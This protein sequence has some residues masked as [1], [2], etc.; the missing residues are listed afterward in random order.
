MAREER[1]PESHEAHHEQDVHHV[2]SPTQGK[3]FH[4]HLSGII[5]SIR[6]WCTAA[7]LKMAVG[8]WRKRHFLSMSPFFSYIP[9]S[10]SQLFRKQSMT[11][12]P[13]FLSIPIRTFIAVI[14]SFSPSLFLYSRSCFSMIGRVGGGQGISLGRGCLVHGVIV[15][16]LMHA[17]GFYH[18]HSRS[19][20]DR[21]LKILW[22]NINEDMR[23]QFRRNAKSQDILFRPFDFR[24][25]MLYGP[26]LFSRNGQDTMVPIK[27]GARLLD[28]GVKAGLSDEDA[29]SINMLY[30]CSR[31]D[32]A[33]HVPASSTST[34]TTT[35]EVPKTISTTVLSVAPTKKR[36]KNKPS[37]NKYWDKQRDPQAKPMKRS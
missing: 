36:R 18:M 5:V 27:R 21:Y 26:K 35:T 16:E 17:I 22:P 2:C 4:P 9:P 7:Y 20:R 30:G 10:K 1:H 24:S 32:D 33:P 15:H 19:D 6:L 11:L 12:E 28:T 23:S 34:T 31:P 13:L 3:E 37:W 29:T 25:I 8:W 14:T